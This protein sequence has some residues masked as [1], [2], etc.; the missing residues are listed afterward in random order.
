M[1]QTPRGARIVKALE[2]FADD[3]DAGAPTQ[4]RYTVRSVRVIPK[5]STYLPARVQAVRNSGA[6]NRHRYRHERS[7]E[8]T[9]PDRCK[10]RSSKARKAISSTVIRSSVT[11]TL[12]FTDLPR[13]RSAIAD[14]TKPF[15]PRTGP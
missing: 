7:G 2:Q 9:R 5:P 4:V 1:S 6:Y 15:K 3:L 8:P 14:P 10:P 13:D 12:G 11:A